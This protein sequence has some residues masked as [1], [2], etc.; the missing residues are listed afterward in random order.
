MANVT[1]QLNLGNVS[2]GQ[3]MLPGATTAS[4]PTMPMILT[5]TPA[6]GVT[7]LTVTVIGVSPTSASGDQPYAITFDPAIST[8]PNFN[9]LTPA[10]VMV[11]SLIV[12]TPTTL[13]TTKSAGAQHTAQF[14]VALQQPAAADVTL[15][16]H[17]GNPDAGQIFL[18][19]AAQPSDPTKPIILTF[20]QQAGTTPLTVK[21]VGLQPANVTSDVTYS[22]TFDPSK[23]ADPN[24][25]GITP[26]S[27]NVTEKNQ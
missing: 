25:N 4:D 9:G 5:F 13:T 11:N 18:P 19:G 22:I 8:D 21:V 12:A 16:L 6:N 14:T 20:P 1:V 17:L 26:S 3:I 10:S 23:S 2:E 7:P 27:I 24:L 15:Q